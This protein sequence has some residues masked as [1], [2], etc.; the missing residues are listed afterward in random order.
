VLK[1]PKTGMTRTEESTAGGIVVA[2][3]GP[4]VGCGVASGGF[5]LVVTSAASFFGDARGLA[6]W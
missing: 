3:G 2:G 5:T 4:P 6:R 1:N